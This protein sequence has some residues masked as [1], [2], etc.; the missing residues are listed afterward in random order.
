[1]AIDA[2][3]E[4]GQTERA[5]ALVDAYRPLMAAAPLAMAGL[6]AAAVRVASS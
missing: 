6:A 1:V 5:Q 2:Y 4:S 3:R